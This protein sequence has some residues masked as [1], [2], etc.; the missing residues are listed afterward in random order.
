M[1]CWELLYLFC[2]L[3]KQNWAQEAVLEV[4]GILCM[5][6]STVLGSREDQLCWTWTKNLVWSSALEKANR[7]CRPGSTVEEAL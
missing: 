2:I 3:E 4:A 7:V 5:T 6:R 1:N